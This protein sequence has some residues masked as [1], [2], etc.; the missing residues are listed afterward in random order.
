MCFLCFRTFMHWWDFLIDQHYDLLF[1]WKNK[2]MSTQIES[3]NLVQ[4]FSS[5]LNIWRKTLKMFRPS[6]LC[7]QNASSLILH[8]GWAFVSFFGLRGYVPPSYAFHVL[9]EKNASLR[10]KECKNKV[11][12]YRNLKII[13]AFVDEKIDIYM[14]LHLQHTLRHIFASGNFSI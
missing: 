7:F 11:L 13:H 3:Q 14:P 5:R 6:E 4:Y 1:I 2:A 12:N 9:V 8:S 10:W